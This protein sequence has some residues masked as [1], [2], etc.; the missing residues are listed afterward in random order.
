MKKQTP[1][2]L[3]DRFTPQGVMVKTRGETSL[4]VPRK[5][6]S[7]LLERIDSR[8]QVDTVPVVRYPGVLRRIRDMWR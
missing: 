2:L 5:P 8:G 4:V 6:Y 1:L 7:L 3:I